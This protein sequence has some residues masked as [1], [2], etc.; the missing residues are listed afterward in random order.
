[1]KKNAQ[2]YAADY[3]SNDSA[4]FAYPAPAAVDWEGSDR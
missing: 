2:R 4:D 1:M 3:A